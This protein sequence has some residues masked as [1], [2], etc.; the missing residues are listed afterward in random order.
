MIL[1][2][3]YKTNIKRIQVGT[4]WL[5]LWLPRPAG[6]LQLFPY[7]GQVS[8]DDG[9][10]EVEDDLDF[11]ATRLCFKA[12]TLSSSNP[13]TSTWQCE[14]QAVR[15]LERAS[16]LLRSKFRAFRLCLS[17]SLNLSSGRPTFIGALGSSPYMSIFGILSSFILT[18]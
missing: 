1:K 11:L 18:T 7:T 4:R 10:D 2:Q 9:C 17:L 15:S 16:Q 12:S 5:L 13:F 3:I 14:H 8:D 6:I